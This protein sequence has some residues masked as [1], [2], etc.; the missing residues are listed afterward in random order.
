MKTKILLLSLRR[1]LKI[2]RLP[3][4]NRRDRAINRR[5]FLS[6]PVILGSLN[7][8]K[9][10][11]KKLTLGMVDLHLFMFVPIRPFRLDEE[12]TFH[13]HPDSHVTTS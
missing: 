1:S 11:G 9:M 12:R 3:A 2:E 13:R 10:R 6:S 4:P 5:T 8:L 7:F